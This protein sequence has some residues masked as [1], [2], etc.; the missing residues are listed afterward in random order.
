MSSFAT[1]P[2]YAFSI[3]HL[4]P[5]ALHTFSYA[6]PYLHPISNPI[7]VVYKSSVL[8]LC[9]SVHISTKSPILSL[10]V[11]LRASCLSP[12]LCIFV[13]LKSR[14]MT[15]TRAWH[16]SLCQVLIKSLPSYFCWASG[17]PLYSPS[18]LYHFLCQTWAWRTQTRQISSH[19]MSKPYVYLYGKLDEEIYMDQPEGYLKKGQEKKVCHLLKSLYGLRQ[20]ALQWNKELHKSLLDLG[21][22]CTWS[23]AVVYF[24][25]V[26]TDITI[27]IVY[28]DDVFFMGSNPKLIKGEKGKFMGV[29]L[30]QS[31]LFPL[32]YFLAFLSSRCFPFSSQLLPIPP[33]HLAL[34]CS[35]FTYTLCMAMHNLTIS[36]QGLSLF[37]MDAIFVPVFT[38][39]F[40]IPELAQPGPCAVYPPYIN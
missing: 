4:Y 20:S 18:S 23:D 15:L 1:T 33:E 10:D 39:L 27:V 3:P 35:F 32:S 29:W 5:H 25:F 2:S 21:F 34:K 7:T 11:P 13:P 31:L 22:I 17:P 16:T 30:L 12:H 38:Q 24:K 40:P 26:G 19:L 8:H 6:S 28:V 9:T 37:P 14:T 36:S